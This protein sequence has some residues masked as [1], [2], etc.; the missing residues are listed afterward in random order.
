M[1]NKN[2]MIDLLLIEINYLKY[3]E[4][5]NDKYE[6]LIKESEEINISFSLLILCLMN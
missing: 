6:K 1:F 2:E 4:V 5:F 3:L